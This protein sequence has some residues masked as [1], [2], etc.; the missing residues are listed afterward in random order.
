MFTAHDAYMR[1]FD[2]WVSADC[3]AAERRADHVAALAR[4]ERVVKADIRP[5]R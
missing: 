5:Y 2:L 3:A 1:K 4:L